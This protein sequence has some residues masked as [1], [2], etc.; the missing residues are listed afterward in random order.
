MQAATEVISSSRDTPAID[1][2]A[3]SLRWRLLVLRLCVLSIL[4]TATWFWPVGAQYVAIAPSFSCTK[5]SQATEKTICADPILEK[6]D[7]DHYAYYQDNLSAAATFGATGI[8]AALKKSE[9]EFIDTRD[10]CGSRRWCIER[11]YLYRDIGISDMSGEPHR[12]TEP[13]RVYV[14]HYV[15]AYLESRLRTLIHGQRAASYAAASRRT[16]L[17]C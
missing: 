15:G 14:N 13:L 17:Q 9:A 11:A 16:A 8:A 12:V 5:A 3:P 6:V 2:F 1:G 4:L 10:L 7:A